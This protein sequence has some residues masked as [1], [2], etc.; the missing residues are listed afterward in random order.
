MRVPRTRGAVSGLVI[1]ILGVWSALIPFIG[2]SFNYAIGPNQSWHWTSGRLWLSVIPGAVALIGGLILMTS[3]TRPTAAFGAL[4]GVLAGAWLVV[5]PTVSELWNHG[6]SQA[7]TPH[8]SNGVRVLEQLG[9]FLAPGALMLYFG[10]AALGRLSIRSVRDIELA[11][12]GAAA[13][14]AGT[15]GYAAGTAPAD[16]TAA[17]RP[18]T[19]PGRRRRGFLRRRE[20]GT[21]TVPPR[22]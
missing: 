9:W 22:R 11:E 6:V 13:A 1:A 12:G 20:A 8:G 10:A 3:A 5:G 14:G 2:P 16:E 19:A 21:T 15:A 17:A 18:A 7:G 4:L